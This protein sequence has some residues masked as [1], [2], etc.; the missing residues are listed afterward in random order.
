[1][2]ET[3]CDL[4]NDAMRS[5]GKVANPHRLDPIPEALDDYDHS[6]TPQ[7]REPTNAK[8]NLALSSM[9]CLPRDVSEAPDWESTTPESS[10]CPGPDHGTD[11]NK[12]QQVKLARKWPHHP[13][14]P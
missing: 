8:A 4:A 14:G 12:P 13:M 9:P 2:S 5:E 6:M 10:P 1:M 3:V 7:T 11:D